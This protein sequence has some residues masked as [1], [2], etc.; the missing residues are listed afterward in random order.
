MRRDVDALA[1]GPFDL[2]VLGGGITGAG[3]AL[4][5]ASRGLRVALIDKGDFAGGTSS[6]SS[7]LIHGGL[8]YLEQADFGLVFEA[9]QERRRLLRNAPHLVRPLRFVIPF[10]AGTRVPPWRWRLG[11]T[12]YDAL[13]GRH[14]LR[15]SRSRGTAELL[16]EF[17]ALQ[18]ASLRG[19]AEYWDAQMDDARLCIEV[20]QTAFRHG[21]IVANYVEAT[22]FESLN[23]AFTGVRALDHVGG[24]TFSI[25]ARQVVNAAGPWV[26]GVRGLA[27]EKDSPML[28]P[29]KGVH[30][31]APYCGL[32]AAFL[33]LHPADERVLF[34]IPWMGKT[35]IGTTDT[36]A[37]GPADELV[38]SPAEIRYLLDAY[39]HYFSPALGP[40][41]VL[42][43]FAGLRPL[44]RARPG[45]PSALSREFR[46][47]E[48]SAGLLSI[49]GGKYTTYRAMAEAAV[50]AVCRRLGM[51]RRCVTQDLPL[52][53]T[54]SEPWTLFMSRAAAELQYRY[55]L[56]D[57]SA[58]HLA[59]RYGRRAYEVAAYLDSDPSLAQPVTAGE[60]DLQ[61]E[62][63]YQRA[64]EMAIHDAD[65]LFRR[66]RLG[67]F[68]GTKSLGASQITVRDSAPR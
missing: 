3:V 6:A 7:K 54:P 2:L 39:N 31:I 42:G 30:I 8:R 65:C 29:T 16:R 18:P 11:L 57:G 35:L 25:R 24:G 58:R 4:D 13:A 14:N 68:E 44:A 34:V 45:Q 21:A 23:A 47:V 26:D 37:E 20:V 64:H 55:R 22:S 49:V 17:P 43:T 56:T 10:F 63:V 59:N 12:L 48:S 5:A 9:L 50:D 1:D 32:N 53:G 61:V 36:L 67:L 27:G 60:P 41:E 33:L 28:R 62:F 40:A 51:R 15:R 52:D 66:T 46:L 19:G 38:V